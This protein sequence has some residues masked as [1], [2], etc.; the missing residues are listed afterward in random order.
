MARKFNGSSDYLISSGVLAA[1]AGQTKFTL[2]CW[3]W[4]NAFANGDSLAMELSA[5][6]NSNNGA[7]VFD[8]DSSDGKIDFATQTSNTFVGTF[9]YTRPSAGAWHHYVMELNTNGTDMAYIDGV[10]QT[11]ATHSQGFTFNGSYQLYFMSRGGGSLFLAGR[12]HEVAIWP[13][14]MLPSSAAQALYMGADPRSIYPS[15]LAYYWP[16]IPSG[17]W[18]ENLGIWGTNY[19]KVV[20]TQPVPPPPVPP[21][22][23]AGFPWRPSLA[24][25]PTR[26]FPFYAVESELPKDL[27]L[28]G[29]SRYFSG[30]SPVPIV[31]PAKPLLSAESAP[32]PAL[33]APGSTQSFVGAVPLRIVKPPPPLQVV[34]S[35]PQD[36]PPGGS[37]QISVGVLPVPIVRPLPP[38]HVAESAPPPALLCPGTTQIG[39]GVV[40]VPIV[41][42]GLALEAFPSE[43]QP[44]LSPGTVQWTVGAIAPPSPPPVPRQAQQ[45]DGLQAVLLGGSVVYAAGYAQTPA[46]PQIIPPRPVEAIQV[47]P[48]PDVLVVRTQ[49]FTGAVPVPIVPH[50]QAVIVIEIAP[51]PWP[52]EGEVQS[53]SGLPE[54][55][56]SP[57]TPAPPL[58][59]PSFFPVFGDDWLKKKRRLLEQEEEEILLAAAAYYLD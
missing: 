40:P 39:L 1:F 15:Y 9:T 57:A 23:R 38:W 19:A 51:Q 56:P 2:S 20:G 33:L 42:P 50:T 44:I 10:S 4:V 25:G 36:F 3:I 49:T 17:G 59:R 26:R 32:V 43:W 18:E 21:R 16:I 34:Q 58:A 54:A 6:Y 28:T 48:Q 8:I 11:G 13:G 37:T 53:S 12:L 35:V 29:T 27:W 41:R 31:Q 47:A 55:T 52:S 30:M 46:P 22:R 14:I 5:N 45:S 24:K 7:W